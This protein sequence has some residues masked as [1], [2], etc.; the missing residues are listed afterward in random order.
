MNLEDLNE[1]SKM[2][3]MSDLG[4]I[5]ETENQT[6]EMGIEQSTNQKST[7]NEI[8]EIIE[9]EEDSKLFIFQI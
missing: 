6:N 2:I 8:H 5:K 3:E 4:F 1:K 9:N 7:W